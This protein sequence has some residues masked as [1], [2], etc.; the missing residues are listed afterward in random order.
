MDE[1]D[2][3]VRCIL[4]TWILKNIDGCDNPRVQGKGLTAG[5]IGKWRYRVGDYRILCDIRD[6]FLIVLAI[7]IG[8]RRGSTA[9]PAAK[10]A[11]SLRNDD[12]DHPFPMGIPPRLTPSHSDCD[13][14]HE[15]ENVGGESAEFSP[16]L[17]DSRLR[18]FAT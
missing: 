13:L 9:D 14:V 3:G 17:A 2:P 11:L 12:S 5:L 15:V 18:A 7:E 1:M 6:E 16:H 10:R 8:H 4:I